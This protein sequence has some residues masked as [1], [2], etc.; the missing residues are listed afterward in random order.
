[1][2]RFYVLADSDSNQK[3]ELKEDDRA[4]IAAWLCEAGHTCSFILGSMISPVPRL[5]MYTLCLTYVPYSSGTIVITSYRVRILLSF[6]DLSET[7]FA[8]TRPL[9]D[10]PVSVTYMNPFSC[11]TTYDYE[12]IDYLY[13]PPPPPH[14]P[15][16]NWYEKN[17]DGNVVAEAIQVHPVK[18]NTMCIEEYTDLEKE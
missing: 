16:L 6:D 10:T 9:E 2:V 15:S 17:T 18:E 11:F 1:M 12:E 13:M 5:P 3:H 4:R 8:W 7:W 14:P